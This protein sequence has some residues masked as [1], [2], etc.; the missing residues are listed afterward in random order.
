MQKQTVIQYIAPL[1]A[2]GLLAFGSASAADVAMANPPKHAAPVTPTQKPQPAAAP[3][4]SAVETAGT[5]SGAAVNVRSGPGTQFGVVTTLKQGDEVKIEATQ[6]GWLSIAWPE[7]ASLWISKEGAQVKGSEATLRV[8]GVLHGTASNKGEPVSKLEPGTKLSVLEERNGWLKVKA[9]ATLRVF[10]SAKFVSTDSK[11]PAAKPEA[12][13]KVGVAAASVVKPAPAPIVKETA[14]AKPAPAPVAAAP[15]PEIRETA[16]VFAPPAAPIEAPPA[17]PA[18]IVESKPI[19]SLPPAAPAPIAKP[20]HGTIDEPRPAP[21]K[22]MPVTLSTRAQIIT[23]PSTSAPARPV[24]KPAPRVLTANAPEILIAEPPKQSMYLPAPGPAADFSEAPTLMPL[25]PPE[26]TST[27]ALAPA[28]APALAPAP[29]PAPVFAR[30]PEPAP[31]PIISAPPPAPAPAP[32]I[33]RSAPPPPAVTTV[34]AA[35]SIHSGSGALHLNDRNFSAVVENRGVAI[36]DFNATW[37]GP[38]RRM[39]PVVEQVANEVRD[40]AAIAKLDVDESPVTASRYDVHSIP[41][42]IIFKDGR[43]VERHY[44]VHEPQDLKNWIQQ[45]R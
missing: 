26:L 34:S 32:V 39:G 12:E 40:E 35:A 3:E 1:V 30:A 20:A 16:K 14:K 43:E 24:A 19:A 41:C 11:K 25:S 36:V 44:G 28:P 17:E 37:C 27:P 29:A 23:P 9:P 18:K 31:A 10:I 6:T 21:A 15:K 7:N 45:H 13:T 4:T 42:L 38:C 22:P 5:V 2:M 33:T 8:A